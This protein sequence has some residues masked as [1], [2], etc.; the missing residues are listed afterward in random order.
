MYQ[1]ISLAE[2][3]PCKHAVGVASRSAQP[4]ARVQLVSLH[5]TDNNTDML[6]LEESTIDCWTTHRVRVN[7]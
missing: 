6:A 1:A 7:R 3:N 2:I 4:R 5:R